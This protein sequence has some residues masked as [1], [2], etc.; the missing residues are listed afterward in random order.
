MWTSASF[1][2]L[3][4]LLAFLNTRRLAPGAFQVVAA[5][6]DDGMQVFHVLYRDLLD[7]D[8]VG[9]AVQEAELLPVVEGAAADDAAAA[10]VAAEEILQGKD[11]A[12]R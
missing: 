2:S 10:V 12:E 6:E 3:P 1:G 4:D 7:Q 9:Q 8:A 11:D 5:R